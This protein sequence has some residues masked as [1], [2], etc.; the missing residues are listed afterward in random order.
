MNETKK[1]NSTTKAVVQFEK[2]NIKQGAARRIMKKVETGIKRFDMIK[3]RRAAQTIED[4]KKI[5]ITN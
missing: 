1:H 4:M 5:Y 2:G 3:K